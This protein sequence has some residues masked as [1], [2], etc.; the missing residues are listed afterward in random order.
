MAIK[1]AHMDTSNVRFCIQMCG[2]S[3]N[4]I[5]RDSNDT[6]AEVGPTS[7]DVPLLLMIFT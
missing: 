4:E 7:E 1:P 3:K 6:T 2:E 5:T